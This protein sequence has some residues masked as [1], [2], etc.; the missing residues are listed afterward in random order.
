MEYINDFLPNLVINWCN[1]EKNW[2]TL[3]WIYVAKTAVGGRLE[4]VPGK[5]FKSLI[6]NFLVIWGIYSK[7]GL[8]TTWWFPVGFLGCPSAVF[9]FTLWSQIMQWGFLLL[10]SKEVVLS[11]WYMIYV[12]QQCSLT[13]S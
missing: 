10:V 13:V 4:C 7:V 11:V 1:H 2:L 5:S 8:G 9:G 12:V 3:I 6:N